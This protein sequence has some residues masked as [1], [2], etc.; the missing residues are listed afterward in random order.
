MCIAATIEAEIPQLR[1]FIGARNWS[2][3]RACRYKKLLF[4]IT[5]LEKHIAF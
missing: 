5:L 4:K 1:F 2:G 3:K